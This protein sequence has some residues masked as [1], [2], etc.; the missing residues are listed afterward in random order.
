MDGFQNM[1]QPLR[2]HFAGTVSRELVHRQSVSEVFLTGIY[3]AGN[4]RYTVWGQWPRWHVFYGS[5]SDRFDSALV[6][7]TLRQ[8]TVL[9]AHTQLG[10]PLDRQFLM[11]TMSVAMASGATPDPWHPA[12][13]T[14]EVLVREV[15]RTGQGIAGMRTIA[16]FWVNG[17]KIAE[18]TASARIVAPDAYERLRSRKMLPKQRLEV[19]PVSAGSVGHSSDWNVVVGK[20]D[21][22]GCWPL[23]VDVSNPILFDHPLDH[24]P[25][26]LLIEAVRQALRLALLEPAADFV[27]LDAQFISIAELGDESRVVLESLSDETGSLTVAASIQVEGTVLMRAIAEVRPLKVPLPVA[28]EDFYRKPVRTVTVGPRGSLHA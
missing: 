15:K 2:S 26:V 7:E 18:G 8:L 16:T 12:E 24:V 22:P 10:V 17:R 28:D 5:G 11:P 19:L 1:D 23:R 25:G 3:S 13:V 9:I 27:T 20:S 14:A 4:D 21:A 6:V